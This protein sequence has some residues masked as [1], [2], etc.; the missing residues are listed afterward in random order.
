MT[1][2][3]QTEN[4]GMIDAGFFAAYTQFYRFGKYS[5]ITRHFCEIGRELAKDPS[6]RD[7]ILPSYDLDT[8]FRI[9]N[10]DLQDLLTDIDDDLICGLAPSLERIMAKRLEVSSQEMNSIWKDGDIINISISADYQKV[11]I[12]EYIIPTFD[13][14]Y[15]VYDSAKGGLFGW[16][17]RLIPDFSQPTLES[18]KRSLNPI[19][20]EVQMLMA[21]SDKTYS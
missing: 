9:M 18:I 15:L 19:Y 17:P 3:L 6:K 12:G 7:L 20:A 11:E 13:L 4:H 8:Y 1:V 21:R 2:E 10:E 14:A 5:F 16:N